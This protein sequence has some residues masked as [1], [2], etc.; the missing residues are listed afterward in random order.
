[1]DDAFAAA[2]HLNSG[3]FAPLIA[4][5]LPLEGAPEGH[6]RLEQ[7]DAAGKLVVRVR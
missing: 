5:V 4:E 1:M 7:G 6:R 3:A 2:R